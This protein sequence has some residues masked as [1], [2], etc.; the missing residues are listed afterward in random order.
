MRCI[1]AF[2][3]GA[4]KA[5]IVKTSPRAMVSRRVCLLFI[6]PPVSIDFMP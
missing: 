1:F 6:T 4:T 3:L 2:A 5:A